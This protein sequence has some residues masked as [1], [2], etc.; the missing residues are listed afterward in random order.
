[1]MATNGSLTVQ[2]KVHFQ[3]KRHGRKQMAVGEAPTPARVPLGR[4]PRVSRLMALAIRFDGLL[5]T[6]LFD[7][8]TMTLPE[9]SAVIRLPSFGARLSRFEITLREYRL[10]IV[11]SQHASR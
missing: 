10:L 1:M 2:C 11:V 7:R 9:L 4:V 6:L 3:Q 8:P 5:R